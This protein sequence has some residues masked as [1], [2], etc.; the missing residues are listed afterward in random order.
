M[1]MDRETLLAAMANV[2][3][4]GTDSATIGAE[5]PAQA[6][7]VEVRLMELQLQMQERQLQ[8]QREMQERQL[9]AQVQREMQQ[10]KLQQEMQ[11][12]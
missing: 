1:D 7:Y 10:L 8:A 4:Q 5:T 6:K 12:K 3:C 9:Q 2:M 11:E